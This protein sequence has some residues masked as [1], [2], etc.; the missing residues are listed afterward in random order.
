MIRVPMQQ[1]DDSSANGA[2]VD[3]GPVAPGRAA[4]PGGLDAEA[5]RRLVEGA[6]DYAIFMLNPDGVVISWNDGAE[7]IKGYRA[8]EIIGRHF[9]V[10]YTQEALDAGWPAEELRRARMLGRFEDEGWRVRKDGGLFWANV[11]ITAIRDA[12]GELR[13]YSK[14]TRDLSERRR[15]ERNL[16]ESEE[17]LRLLIE[18]VKDHA[19]FGLD[20]TGRVRDWN[21]GAERVLGFR[22]DE[23]VGRHVSIFFNEED[24]AAGK[25]QCELDAA[26]DS[27]YVEAA[28]W[29]VKADGTPLWTD[30]T[31]TALRERDGGLRGFVQI[32]HD[33]S[34]RRR[35][36]ELESE[37]RRINEFIAMLSHELRNPLGP[38]RNAVGILR[39][40]DP[41]PEAA[42]SVQMIERQV[43]HLSRLVD[44]L[45]DVSRVTSGKVHLRRKPLELNQL[46]QA[47]VDSARP[48]FDARG[49]T[50]EVKLAAQ[51]LPI[52]GDATRLT[53]AIVNL[54]TNAAK[55]T[56][57]GGVVR[58]ETAARGA[59]AAVHVTDNGIGMSPALMA[60]AFGLFVQGERTL[61]R[62]EGGLGIGLALVKSLV[63]LHG[64]E[65]AVTSAGPGHGSEFVITLPLAVAGPNPAAAAPAAA[66]A[67]RPRR[68]LVVDDNRDAV[69]SL[70]LLLQL[71]GNEVQIAHDGEE[72]LRLAGAGALDAVV[73]DVGLPTINGYEVARRLRAMPAL[74]GTRL[75]ALTGYG[76][77]SDRRSAAEAGF[78]A[79][80]VKPVDFDTLVRALDR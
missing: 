59:V 60:T 33:L 30:I 25:P 8:D 66:V 57:D 76:R 6:R 35:V 46:L 29:R 17:N 21:A 79:H 34:E 15:N 61:D 68:I 52:Q 27:G 20:A 38:I 75:I 9:S 58:V 65:V 51:A 7:R 56:P 77:D 44:D 42:S 72:A 73:L 1:S 36:H 70:A 14:I 2:A 19:I 63:T 26:R 28:G 71:D 16:A 40:V 78:D 5:F 55:Y 67:H 3:A 18:G 41:R 80:F 69:A 64:G 47:A 4:A 31:L 12:D 32:I 13:G 53:Q 37:G 49:H 50:L 45:L 10:F 62:S 24:V 48:G 39:Q 22:R 23:V 74:R 11:V 54:L 43:A